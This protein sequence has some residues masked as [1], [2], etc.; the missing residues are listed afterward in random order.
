MDAYHII[1]VVVLVACIVID[2]HFFK[3]ERAAHHT[4]RKDL[5]DR[6]GEALA[7]RDAAVRAVRWVPLKRPELRALAKTGCEQCHSEGAIEV[8]RGGGKKGV[9]VCFCVMK[10]IAGRGDYA[11]VADGVPVRL[12]T[13]SELDLLLPNEKTGNVTPI[14]RD[15]S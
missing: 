9:D 2:T 3:R 13:Q 4:T 10:K 7:Q 14:R 8:H 6:L 5:T 1:L 12:A 11:M 15:V